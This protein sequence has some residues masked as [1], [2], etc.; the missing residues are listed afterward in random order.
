MAYKAI[1]QPLQIR[2]TTIRNRIFSSG[3]VP[4][5]TPEG[6]P[7]ERYIAYCT[8]KAKGGIGLVTFGGSTNI[9][10][11]SSTIFS[12]L[13]VRS[14]DDIPH[15]AALAKSVKAEGATI[16]C[17]ITHM[18]RHCK[19]DAGEWLPLI[20]PSQVRDIGGARSM[21]REM[22]A[23]DIARAI[24]DYAVGASRLAEAG[25]DGVEIISSMHL[26]GQFL[27]PLSNQRDDEYGGSLD[28]R[29]RFLRELLEG[30]RA[31]A[32]EDFIVGVRY[33]AD[34]G[35]EGGIPAAEGIE[36]GRI[37]GN[38]GVADFLNVNGAYSGTSQGVNDAFPGMESR[39]AP[40]LALAGDVRQ[41]SG[42]PTM[43]ASRLDTLSTAEHAVASGAVDMAGMTR[44]HIADPHILA[45]TM[46]GEE[47]RIRPCV[48]AG[49][50]L[51]R[52][53]RGLDALCLH[54]P[55]TGR[56]AHLPHEITPAQKAR[57]AVVVGGGP[58]GLEA[59][60]VLALRG[61]AVTLFEATDRLGGQLALAAQAGWRKGLQ[62]VIDWLSAE[63][64]ELNVAVR[65]NVL[66]GHEDIDALAPDIAVVATGGLP[67]K[68]LE[69]G[70]E[71]LALSIWDVLATKTMPTARLL[72]YDELGGHAALS[73]AQMAG[74]QG[75]DVHVVTP[76]ALIGQ[77]LGAQNRPVYMRNLKKMG[78]TL[79]TDMF[80]LGL[81]REGNRTVATFRDRWTKELQEETF[82]SVLIDQGVEPDTELVDHLA[83]RAKTRDVP[84]NDA[85]V[86]NRSQ[87]TT[88]PNGKYQL[89]RIGD[90]L[91]SRDAHAAIYEARRLCRLL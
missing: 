21:A 69:R 68:R 45:K 2:N 80:L 30:V 90:A 82:D 85:M 42:L 57:K 31:A 29:T 49:Y 55:S 78:A 86:E 15:Y 87:P 73:T 91:M 24:K 84:D 52:P 7:N 23:E 12:G 32:P 37:L 18:G 5:Y 4:A 28:N 75:A 19:W 79:T 63:L 26:P 67:I 65:L 74:E 20:A 47:H 72:V 56:E 33:T 34:E 61:H 36:V 88:N 53:Y 44:P 70:G 54:N 71:D 8:E 60:R 48:G 77:D 58:A 17:Q 3:H 50:C 64:E 62:G 9:A 1:F 35:N 89:L 13:S 14:N 41:A 10:R 22:V 59:A 40:H 46:R 66:A 38:H 11:D 43:Q 16:M 83:P 51:D 6:R 81:R 25:L 27:S 76:D 39:S